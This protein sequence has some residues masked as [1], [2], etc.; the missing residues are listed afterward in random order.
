MEA[1]FPEQTLT[2]YLSGLG[3][4]NSNAT[5][6]GFAER[7]KVMLKVRHMLVDVLKEENSWKASTSKVKRDNVRRPAFQVELAKIVP[8]WQEVV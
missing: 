4:L 7:A 1:R 2:Y 5:R 6:K 8:G 3:N